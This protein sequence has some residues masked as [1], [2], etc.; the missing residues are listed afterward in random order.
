MPKYKIDEI[1]PPVELL[2]KPRDIRASEKKLTWIKPLGPEYITEKLKYNTIRIDMDDDNRGD[3][4]VPIYKSLM[5]GARDGLDWKDK[6]AGSKAAETSREWMQQMI[7][8]AQLTVENVKSDA[9]Q[10]R[11]LM[12]ITDDQRDELNMM[13]ALLD[14]AAIEAGQA[15]GL[16]VARA[17]EYSDTAYTESGKLTPL[18]EEASGATLKQ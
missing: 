1:T 7:N 2:V 15:A 13:A 3:K 14:I 18:T 8:Q 12:E 17:G 10:L 6:M 9:Y 11:N 16:T 4:Y 5:K